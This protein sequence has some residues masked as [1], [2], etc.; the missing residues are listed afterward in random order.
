[1]HSHAREEIKKRYLILLKLTHMCVYFDLFHR[2][3]HSHSHRHSHSHSRR[4]CQRHREWSMSV[5]GHISNFF[6]SWPFPSASPPLPFPSP[7][8][9]IPLFPCF[10][11]LVFPRTVLLRL[12][13]LKLVACYL[14]SV[15]AAAGVAAASLSLSL[16]V[17]L[18]SELGL[19]YVSTALHTA[20]FCAPFLA[21]QL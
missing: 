9:S 10:P 20:F 16:Q 4:L 19:V 18:K 13:Q 12:F 5:P 15:G 1:M 11:R 3:C 17:D 14:A 6:L 7:S 8:P 2:C 21:A